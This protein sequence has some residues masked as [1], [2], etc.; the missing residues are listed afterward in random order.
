MSLAQPFSPSRYQ[1]S[2]LSPTLFLPLGSL[3]PSSILTL[4]LLLLYS[5]GHLLSPIDGGDYMVV[6][7]SVVVCGGF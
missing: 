6:K 5:Q 2:S 4:T 3:L 1:T 7:Q